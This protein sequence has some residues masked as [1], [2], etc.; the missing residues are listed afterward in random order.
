M[1]ANTSKSILSSKMK[2]SILIYFWF[3]F[4]GTLPIHAY[5]ILQYCD[6]NLWCTWFLAYSPLCSMS[7]LYYNCLGR[8]VCSQ[9]CGVI[10]GGP[11]ILKKWYEGLFL[12]MTGGGVVRYPEPVNCKTRHT[13]TF[14]F[15]KVPFRYILSATERN[16]LLCP[17]RVRRIQYLVEVPKVHFFPI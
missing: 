12:L 5:R 17:L 8:V 1:Y 7:S 15:Y 3:G 14:E 11:V 10:W 6:Q 13:A 4:R 16:I 9:E 2:C